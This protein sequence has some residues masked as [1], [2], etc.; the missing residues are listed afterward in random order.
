[1]VCTA[2]VMV[3]SFSILGAGMVK[4]RNTEEQTDRYSV[5]EL[6]NIVRVRPVLS[7]CATVMMSSTALF[8]YQSSVVY[9][10]KYV[11]KDFRFFS[12]SNFIGL[13]GALIGGFALPQIAMKYS[14]IRVY[15]VTVTILITI[16]LVQVMNYKI[17]ILFYVVA[18]VR[19]IGISMVTILQYSLSADNVTYIMRYMNIT[20]AGAVASLNSLAMKFSLGISAVIQG[21]VL[22]KTGYMAN[23]QQTEQATM[24]ILAAAF[25]IPA[26]FYVIAALIFKFGYK[27]IWIVQ[28]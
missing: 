1:M 28:K 19:Q 11:L 15:L 9:Y 18:F 2:V 8:L 27:R 6:W 17:I 23:A 13:G 12:I 20:G 10:I 25:V 3:L 16:L 24:G 26:V 14:K 4:E 7:L 5:R 22:D 21:F